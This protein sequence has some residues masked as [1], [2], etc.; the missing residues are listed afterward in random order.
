M[1]RFNVAA[2]AILT[3]GGL[4]GWLAGAG[5][6]TRTFAQERKADPPATEGTPN[7]L[8]RPDFK[9]PGKV[10]KTYKRR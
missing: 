1:T 7:V 9:F 6:P 3:V 8:P 4:L 2:M 10:G 5:W